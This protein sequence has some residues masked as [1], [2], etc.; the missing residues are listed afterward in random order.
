METRQMTPFLSTFSA[1]FVIFIF[2]FENGKNLFS[3]VP[4][5]VLFWSVKYLNF[6]QK[7][8]IRNTHHIFL[9]SRNLRLLKSI[10]SFVPQGEPKKVSAYGLIPVCRGI[11]IHYLKISPPTFCCFRFSENYLNPQVRINK[12]LNKY[13]A[14]YQLSYFYGLLR[15]L[16]LQSLS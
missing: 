16:S 1:L 5:F 3:C 14:N 8:P 10:L 2:I 6:E 12:I 7:P 9:E 11:S 4:H 13:T 15:A